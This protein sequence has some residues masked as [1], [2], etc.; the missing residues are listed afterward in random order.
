MSTTTCASCELEVD[1]GKRVDFLRIW[2]TGSP[3]GY[4]LPGCWLNFRR[5]S[6]DQHYPESGGARPW[7]SISMIPAACMRIGRERWLTSQI[8]QSDLVQSHSKSG[9]D[10]Q[11]P[12]V[13]NP[14]HQRSSTTRA[15]MKR[16]QA[17]R[18]MVHSHNCPRHMFARY[19]SRSRKDGCAYS[20]I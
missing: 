6:V 2:W 20:L 12:Q 18:S 11:V 13:I 17:T 5:E 14:N 8:M 4:Q 3:S 7:I 19:H 10:L 1:E 15:G 16:M 9:L